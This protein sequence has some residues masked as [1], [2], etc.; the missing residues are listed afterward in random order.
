MN[1]VCQHEVR[2]ENKNRK[3]IFTSLCTTSKCE[4]REGNSVGDGMWVEAGGPDTGEENLAFRDTPR[5]GTR[6]LPHGCSAA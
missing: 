6:I 2:T 3:G 4:P 5:I 1:R